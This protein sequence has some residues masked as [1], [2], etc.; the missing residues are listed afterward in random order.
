MFDKNLDKNLNKYFH[1][2]T[3]NLPFVVDMLNLGNNS[4]DL[5][6][7]DKHENKNLLKDVFEIDDQY[8]SIKDEDIIDSFQKVFQDY[9][10]V[11][12]PYK[13]PK[14]IHVKYLLDKLYNND[15]VP[16]ELYN[17]FNNSLTNLK[18]KNK[19]IPVNYNDD[20]QMLLKGGSVNNNIK[21][22][23]KDLDKGILRVI[24]L[25]NNRKP[26][27]NLLKDDYKISK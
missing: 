16:K 14:N 15:S 27:N 23:N 9:N 4:A 18:F 8:K 5:I 10:V 13:K 7:V 17:H 2:K 11:Y 19:K 20:G 6:K 12:T 22:N 24:Y 3:N 1:E 21:I 26:T 25:N